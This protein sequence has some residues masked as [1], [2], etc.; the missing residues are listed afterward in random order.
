MGNTKLLCLRVQQAVCGS[1]LDADARHLLM[2]MALLADWRTGVGIAS[3][4]TIASALGCSD[5]HVRKLLSD[6]AERKDSPVMVTRRR[7]GAAA[8]RTSDQYSLSFA[9]P[10]HGAGSG[11]PPEAEQRAGSDTDPNRNSVPLGEPLKLTNQPERHDS[12]TGTARHP[13]RNVRSED[14]ISSDLYQISSSAPR[15]E[16][17]ARKASEKR[18]EKPPVEGAHDLKLHYVAEFKRTRNEEPAFGR[19]WGRAVKAFGD[20]VTT[21]GLERAKRI[22]SAALAAPFGSKTPWA[23]RDNAVNYQG[24]QPSRGRAPEPQRSSDPERAKSWGR[25][26][27]FDAPTTPDPTFAAAAA[28]KQIRETWGEPT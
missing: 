10:E 8:G 15:Q 13:K 5:R 3:Q 25:S 7:R 11:T 17:R 23:I 6:L 22:V 20:L 28:E 12:P 27:T 26:N 16:K 1:A 9:Q 21:Y 2:V 18:D 19:A 4:T 14:Q 24:A